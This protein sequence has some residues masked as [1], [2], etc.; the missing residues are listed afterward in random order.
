MFF[1]SLLSY[2]VHCNSALGPRFCANKIISNH[3]IIRYTDAR[4]LRS[5]ENCAYTYEKVNGDEVRDS[6]THALWTPNKFAELVSIKQ[7]IILQ[8]QF[9][10]T[11]SKITWNNI[12][13]NHWYPP[14]SRVHMKFTK[15]QTARGY[16]KN[17]IKVTVSIVRSQLVNNSTSF[18]SDF[19]NA[20]H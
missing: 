3:I 15:Q 8:N 4:Q 14:C 20:I 17:R 1:F 7:N 11:I 12:L 9:I 2:I 16:L 13:Q 19:V 6:Q 18:Q 5:T 10:Y